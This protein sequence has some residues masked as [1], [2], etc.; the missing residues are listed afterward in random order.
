MVKALGCVSVDREMH[1]E[2]KINPL[3]AQ[4]I[5]RKFIPEINKL[6]IGIAPGPLTVRLKDGFPIDLLQSWI[7]SMNISLRRGFS[8]R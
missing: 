8:G 4:D 6:I 1:L 2:T 7:S 3:D 5:L